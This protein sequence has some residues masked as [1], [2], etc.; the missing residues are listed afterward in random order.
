MPI[1]LAVVIAALILLEPALSLT[2]KQALYSISLSIKAIIILVLPLIIFVLLFKTAATLS[3]GA[4][5]I[6]ALILGLV[7]V[8]NFLAA[9]LSHYVGMLIY[10]FPISLIKPEEN[11]E[12]NPLWMW[13]F[14]TL[15]GNATAMF[16]GI[17]VGLIA[18]KVSP[19]QTYTLSVQLEWGIGKLFSGFLYVMPFFVG[20]F[21]VKLQYDGVMGLIIKDYT[22]VFLVTA[23]A[24]LAYI[25][26]FYTLA[27]RFSWRKIFS[28][29]KNM[30]PAAISGFSTMSSA[31]SM[32]LTLMGV[33]NNLENQD[34]ARSVVPATVNIH[35]M[36]DCFAI[37]I[38]AYAVMK[39]FGMPEPSL[40]VYLT[41]T[42]YFVLAKFS[43]AAVPGG[44]II[45]MLPILE[46]Y[47]GFHSTMLSLITALYILFDPITTSINIL[48]NGAF[49][50]LV[51]S[52]F[53]HKKRRIN[54][55]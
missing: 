42:A 4:G 35:L 46:S 3:R 29:L 48:G 33:Q 32:P 28:N 34:I 16:A 14:P 20:G 38:F 45:V 50:K 24:E 23:L 21:V 26:L 22:A 36:G 41:F 12:L 53:S 43:V 44:G 19:R 47:L 6:L 5:K 31:A 30:L 49:A 37:P 51:D 13:H 8:S 25:L 7:C 55:V 15:L 9:F 18:A 27:N 40:L 2:V 39:S 1:I 10:H 52:L 17:G 54:T 11:H